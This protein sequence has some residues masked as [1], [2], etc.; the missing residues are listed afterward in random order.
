MVR[1]NVKDYTKCKKR[2]PLSA[3][4][5][6]KKTGKPY[7]RCRKCVAAYY[8]AYYHAS[9]ERKQDIVARASANTRK[10][11]ELARAVVLEAFLLGCVDCGETDVR[12]LEFDHQGDKSFTI[13]SFMRKNNLARLREEIAKCHVVCANHHRIRTAAQFDTWRHRAYAEQT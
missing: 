11:E 5:K 13:S 9:P 12:V 1:W 6:K 10:A 2:L 8:K 7:P 3:F 4:A